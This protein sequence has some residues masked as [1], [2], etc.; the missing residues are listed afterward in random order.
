M[1]DNYD[2]TE[3]P[4]AK[5]LKD[6][7][8]KGQVA[9][10]RELATAL[11]LISSALALMF[12]GSWLADSMTSLTREI[13][14][15]DRDDAFDSSKM[16]ESI[17]I[18]VDSV[19]LPVLAFMILS[20][21]G[22]I[23]GSIALGGYNFSWKA[24]EF[25]GSRLSPLQ[26]FKRMFGMNGLVELLKS[27]A[28]VGVI[29]GMALLSLSYF[30]DE[31]LHLDM[32]LYPLN[33]EHAL[34]MIAAAFLILCCG[35][36]PI[37]LIDVPYQAFKHTKELRMSKKDIKDEH[38]NQE[39]DPLVKGRIRRLQ[40]DAANRE[41]MQ[42]VPEA[43]VII[44]NP[45]HFA[46]AIQYKEDGERAPIMVAKGIDQMAMHIRSIASGHDIPIIESPGLARALYYST[47][48][49]HEVP[50]KLF[51]AVAQVLAY[52]FQLREHKRGRAT[53]PRPL[54][55]ELPIPEELRR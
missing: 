37:A 44:T 23:Y 13:L 35:M 8:E 20:L 49:K 24:A 21:I 38:K 34:D 6:A 28:K 18:S 52:V 39:G 54:A 19:T 43:D 51:M 40:Y 55:K 48:V 5:K 50:Q 11:V 17:A 12:F 45:T 14:M 36:L 41:M 9:R 2:K 46:V 22:G 47:E 42:A 10:S 7:R 30:Q 26:G 16:F 25:K 33:I 4:T 53:K 31:A 1:A 3:E 15:M 32:E 27:I 29:I